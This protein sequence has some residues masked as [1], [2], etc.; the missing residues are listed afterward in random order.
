[1]LNLKEPKKNPHLYVQ[2]IWQLG[3]E[4]CVRES[5]KNRGNSALLFHVLVSKYCQVNQY[6]WPSQISRIQQIIAGNLEAKHSQFSGSHL[7]SIVLQCLLR[8]RG[9]SQSYFGYFFIFHFLC[10]VSE[11]NLI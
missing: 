6:V 7:S 11:W 10:L 4:F 8:G 9:F 1:M 2:N 3:F 5:I